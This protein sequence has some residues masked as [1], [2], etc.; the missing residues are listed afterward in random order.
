MLSAPH[1]PLLFI[2]CSTCFSCS[3]RD[4]QL[5]QATS[6]WDHGYH[7][8]P[9]NSTNCSEKFCDM[10]LLSQTQDCLPGVLCKWDSGCASPEIPGQYPSQTYRRLLGRSP[11]IPGYPAVVDNQYFQHAC[12]VYTDTRQ[13]HEIPV[14]VNQPLFVWCRPFQSGNVRP[15]QGLF[16]HIHTKWKGTLQK[17]GG[18][19]EATTTQKQ[20]DLIWVG[21][22]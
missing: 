6:P 12:T 18:G 10:E 5:G 14:W 4:K 15:S 17:L 19:L 2:A 7:Y 16:P 13:I 21:P 20:A 1:H 8:T 9:H 3:A 22:Q 11:P